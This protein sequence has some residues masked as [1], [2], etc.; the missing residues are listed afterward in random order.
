MIV[1]DVGIFSVDASWFLCYHDEGE[2]QPG[3][4]DSMQQATAIATLISAVS[5]L[6]VAIVGAIRLYLEYK[7]NIQLAYAD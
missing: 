2:F 3:G 1:H 5:S 4:V 6:I 7:R